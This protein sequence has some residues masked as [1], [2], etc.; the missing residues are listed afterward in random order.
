[1]A[2]SLAA[3]VQSNAQEIHVAYFRPVD[4]IGNMVRLT[5]TVLTLL[6]PVLLLAHYLIDYPLSEWGK[7]HPAS[8]TLGFL[9]IS[10]CYLRL[11]LCCYPQSE[12]LFGTAGAVIMG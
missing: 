12:T 9:R 7:G 10:P 3:D 4:H 8:R 6:L 2:L 5:S 1:M 11:C